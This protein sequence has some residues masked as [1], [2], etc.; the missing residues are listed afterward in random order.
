MYAGTYIKIICVV[1]TMVLYISADKSI[2]GQVKG[3]FNL[4]NAGP[5]KTLLLSYMRFMRAY[6]ILAVFIVA[7]DGS[8]MRVE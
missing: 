8:I 1:I 7:A 3:F 4:Y 6:T 2:S 5:A